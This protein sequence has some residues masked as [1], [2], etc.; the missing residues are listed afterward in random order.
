MPPRFRHLGTAAA[1]GF[2]YRRAWY[3][4]VRAEYAAIAGLRAQQ[5][6]A[7]RTFVEVYARIERHAFT[8]NAPTLGARQVGSCSS[9][10][11]HLPSTSVSS[12]A[13][14]AANRDRLSSLNGFG[15]WLTPRLLQGDS[16]QPKGD[17]GGTRFSTKLLPV[18]NGR[19]QA[20]SRERGHCV[21]GATTTE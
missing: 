8:G 16:T 20:S 5:R 13:M 6:P 11:V 14:V 2:L 3:R 1:L 10:C 19:Y 21:E 4:P 9:G 12:E 15:S 18:V 7:L 17:L